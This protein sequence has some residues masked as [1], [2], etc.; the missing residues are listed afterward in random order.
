ML[1]VSP[2]SHEVSIMVG[3]ADGV[4]QQRYT[5][6]HVGLRNVRRAHTLAGKT[7]GGKIV[8]IL[9]L[10]PNTKSLAQNTSPLYFQADR[11]PGVLQQI[12]NT[13]DGGF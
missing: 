5:C 11:K 2:Y 6:I 3:K 7:P 9:V 13:H 1:I 12:G 10:I 8:F 4:I